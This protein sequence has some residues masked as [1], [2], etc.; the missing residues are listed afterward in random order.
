MPPHTQA[1]F[2]IN[3]LENRQNQI[4]LLKRFSSAKL[5]PGLWGFPAGHIEPNETPAQTAHREL[6]EEIGPGHQLE[7]LRHIGPVR[8][9]FY[10]GIYEIHLFHVRWLG[11]IIKLNEEHTE[12]AWVTRE[13]YRRYP[14]MHGIDEDI[15]Y[16]Q[17]WPRQFLNPDKLPR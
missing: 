14:V 16:F 17:I 3:I 7:W 11:G 12:F 1:R 13:D 15:D 6:T 4:L 9:S 5:G 8:D 2:S 10:G